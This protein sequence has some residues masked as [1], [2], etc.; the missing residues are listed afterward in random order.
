MGIKNGNPFFGEDYPRCR[1]GVEGIVN[2]L[3]CSSWCSSWCAEPTVSST[4]AT[5][6]CTDDPDGWFDSD[7]S[8]YNCAWYSA[9]SNCADYGDG[10]ANNGV[11]A[12]MACCVC[13]GGAFV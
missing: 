1:S 3:P 7:G 4:A 12:N 5:T 11:T 2:C 10:Y 6:Q 13:G 8:A 9:G